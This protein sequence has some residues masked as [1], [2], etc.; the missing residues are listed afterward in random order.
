MIPRAPLFLGLAG[1]L[2]FI[3]GAVTLV[4]SDLAIWATQT[5]GPRF[6]GPFVMLNYGTIILAF[7]SGV[8]WG[9]AT[10]DGQ[11]INYALSVVPALWV[12]FMVGAG[13]TSSAIFLITGFLGL[14][15][16]DWHFSAQSLT[17]TWWM[18]LRILLTI[19]V[20]ACLSLLVI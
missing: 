3:W 7:M 17:P 18:R 6:V 4:S 10:R 14:L 13:A 15:A 5:I 16:L 8:L 2:P 19:V 12:F 1:L 9:F 20:V 11:A